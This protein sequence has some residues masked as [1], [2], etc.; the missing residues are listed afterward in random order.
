VPILRWNDVVASQ[1]I[2]TLHDWHVPNG[3]TMLSSVDVAAIMWEWLR[4]DPAY[5]DWCAGM[6]EAEIIANEGITVIRQPAAALCNKWGLLFGEAPEIDGAHARLMWSAGVDPFVLKVEA[7]CTGAGF[8]LQRVAQFATVVIDEQS[9][10]HVVLSNGKQRI[11]IDIEDGTM[12]NGPVSLKIIC[13]TPMDAP[14]AMSTLS[15]ASLLWR[16]GRMPNT[17]QKADQKMQRLIAA[18]RV[19]D[20]LASGASR[21]NIARAL[22]GD[23]RVAKEWNSTSDAMRSTVKRLIRLSQHL[24]AGGYRDLMQIRPTHRDK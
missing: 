20:A 22:F 4:R 24:A 23:D 16:L 19:Y 10:E 1:I 14:T 6:K 11:R 18:L 17:E 2:P 12:L 8:D 3:Y 5:V 9:H 7:R 21:Q 15:R 13:H